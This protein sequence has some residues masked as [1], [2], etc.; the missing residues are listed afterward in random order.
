M[1]SCDGMAG[2]QGWPPVVVQGS[3][4]WDGSHEALF[5]KVASALRSLGWNR[6][7]IPGADQAMWKKRLDNGTIASAM[8]NLN[9]LG[10]PSWEFVALGQPAGRAASGC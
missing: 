9:P 1:D 6:T 4:R 5:V 10:D 2:T 8:L 7:Q 3:F